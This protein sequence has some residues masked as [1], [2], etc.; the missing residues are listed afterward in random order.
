MPVIQT[1]V[2]KTSSRGVL[3]LKINVNDKNQK[4]VTFGYDK[5]LSKKL[6][7]SLSSNNTDLYKQ[8]LELNNFCNKTEDI[9]DKRQKANVSTLETGPLI[10]IFFNTKIGLTNLVERFFPSLD[11]A[12]KESYH[13]AQSKGWKVEFAKAM[14]PV[15][16]AKENVEMFTLKEFERNAGSPKGLSSISGRE[17]LKKELNEKIIYPIKYPGKAAKEA[18]EYGVKFPSS[19]LLDGH[20]GCD[21]TFIAEAIA[22]EANLPFFKIGVDLKSLTPFEDGTTMQERIFNALSQ[23]SKEIKKPCVLQIDGLNNLYSSDGSSETVVPASLS[24]IKKLLDLIGT[25]KEKGIIVVSTTENLG[26]GLV[27]DL[28]RYAFDSPI[29]VTLPNKETIEAILKK[30]LANKER[31]VA[32]MKSK[33]DLSQMADKLNG[34][35]DKDIEIL[36]NEAAFIAKNNGERDIKKEDYF[37][38]IEKNPNLKA[39]P[40][41]IN[42]YLS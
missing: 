2:W 7:K 9:I 29:R 42:G 32:L 11:Y 20:P 6:I 22:R 36:S 24:H 4:S 38:A 10:N 41:K 35:S 14:Q 23:K 40:S 28:I 30:N 12:N 19:V 37:K 5:T 27:E 3:N 13:Y 34:F 21:K 17:Q 15:E 16:E 8:M 31:G 26:H 39:K 25:A 33:D 1:I 18:K